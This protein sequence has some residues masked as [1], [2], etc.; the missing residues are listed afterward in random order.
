MR[1]MGHDGER[2]VKIPRV[3]N[4]ES[5][6]LNATVSHKFFAQEIN[7]EKKHKW[8]K[9]EEENKEINI[10]KENPD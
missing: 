4:S 5:Y 9:S 8:E 2:L 1:R 6:K 3:W 7:W 10:R